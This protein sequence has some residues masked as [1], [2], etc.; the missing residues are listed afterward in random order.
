M[1]NIVDQ[2]VYVSAPSPLQR[3]IH[4]RAPFDSVRSEALL[5]VLRTADVIRRRIAETVEPFGITPQQYNVLRILRG[6]GCEGLPTLD[7]AERMIE[8]TPGITRM[9]DRLESKKLVSR[10]RGCNDRRQVVCRITKQ[11]VDLLAMLDLPL[12]TGMASFVGKATEA[13]LTDL[14]HVL[15]QIRAHPD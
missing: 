13:G 6:A 12:R 2:T 14:I 7:I 5:A 3:E 9:I 1:S 15:D 10:E 11:G 4:Q 8:Q